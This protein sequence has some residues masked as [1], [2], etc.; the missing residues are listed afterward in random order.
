MLTTTHYGGGFIAS[1]LVF[2]YTLYMHFYLRNAEKCDKYM[3]EQDR[4][5]RKVAY[6]VTWIS[7]ILSGLALAISG[8]MLFGA[9]TAAG[10]S[11]WNRRGSM[12]GLY[13]SNSYSNM[14]MM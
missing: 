11:Y 9:A 2:V 8:L 1:L 5:F 4:Q 10:R 3:K 7:L 12:P 6:I 13:A 14:D